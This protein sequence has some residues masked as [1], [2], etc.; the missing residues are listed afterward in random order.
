MPATRAV[1]VGSLLAI[2][3]PVPLVLL[4]MLALGARGQEKEADEAD[5]VGEAAAE[6]DPDDLH[7]LNVFL[8]PPRRTLRRLSQARE[9]IARERY[10]DAVRLL[11][12]VLEGDTDYFFQPD[13][14]RPLHRSLKVAAQQL[15]GGIPAEGRELYELQ[16]GPRAQAL[17]EAVLAGESDSSLTEISRRYFH[18]RAGYE[19]TFLLGLREFDQGRPLAAALTLGRLN[20]ALRD[21]R[22][23]PALSLTLAA[24]WL[25]ADEPE[26]ARQALV[27][28][29]A[30]QGGRAPRFAGKPVRWFDTPETA[31]SWLS[32]HMGERPDAAPRATQLWAMVGG[33]PDRNASVDGGMPLLS[34]R[35]RIPVANDRAIEELWRHYVQRAVHQKT[36]V[37]PSLAPLVVDDVVLMRTMSSLLAVDARTG[38]RLWEARGNEQRELSTDALTRAS[39]Q[40]RSTAQRL[41]MQLL[42]RISSDA[43][44]GSLSSDGRLVFAVEDTQPAFSQPRQVIRNA[45]TVSQ[46]PDDS[47]RLAAY[48]VRSGK[49][50]WHLGGPPEDEFPLRQAGSYF[51]GPPLPLR[52]R[53]YVLAEVRGEVSLRVL[54]ANKGDLLWSQPLAMVEP[55]TYSFAPRRYRGLSPSYRDGILICPTGAG[56][57]VAVDLASRSLLW[58]YR[59]EQDTDAHTRQRLII[60]QMRGQT[61]GAA[62]SWA[63]FPPIIADGR[64][65]VAASNAPD[66]IQCLDLLSGDVVWE[67][68]REDSIMVGCVWEGTILLIGPE[69][70]SA[71]KL[72]DGRLAWEQRVV[73]LPTDARPSG[74]GFLSDGL[75]FLPLSTGEIAAI[76]VERGKLE[77]ITSSRDELVPGHLVCYGNLVI[78]QALDGL[79]AFEQRA[80]L[81]R[82]VAAALAKNPNDPRALTRRAELR[83]AEGDLLDAVADLRRAMDQRPDSRTR[84]LLAGA[85][86]EGL[87]SNF[88]QFHPMADQL[89]PLLDTLEQ[90]AEYH[91]AMA[92]GLQES[93]R[94]QAALSHYKQ[95]IL[96]G[97]DSPVLEDVSPFHAVARDRL[98]AVG[99]HDLYRRARP[100]A[101]REIDRYIADQVAEATALEGTG[102]LRELISYFGYSPAIRPARRELLE[103]LVA[104]NRILEAELLLWDDY[105]SDN[106]DRAGP[107][108]ARLAKMM[109]EIGRSDQA[110]LVYRELATRFANV[111][112][113]GEATGAEIVAALPQSH[114]AHSAH[115]ARGGVTAAAFPSGSVAMEQRDLKNQ[116]YMM[117]FV[118]RLEGDGGPFLQHHLARL[119]HSRRRFELIDGLGREVLSV[120]FSRN[121]RVH[122]SYGSDEIFGRLCG[123]LLVARTTAGA[124]A[125]N[126]LRPE[127]EGRML[128]WPDGES[129]DALEDELALG[130]VP[131]QWPGQI[132]FARA[133]VFSN[134]RHQ[135]ELGPVSPDCAVVAQGGAVTGHD[136][137]SGRALW[138]RRDLPQVDMI[139]GDHEYTVVAQSGETR[140]TILRMSDGSTLKQVPM[141][142]GSRNMPLSRHLQTTR[143]R[144]FLDSV[145]VDNHRVIGLYDPVGEKYVWGPKTFESSARVDILHGRAVGV[146]ENEGRFHLLALA[147]GRTLLDEKLP[148]ADD[149]NQ[150]HL[151][152][153]GDDRGLLLVNKSADQRVRMAPLPGTQSQ[154]IG[155]GWIYAFQ[156]QAPGAAPGATN[157][158]SDAGAT[159][160]DAAEA[161]G[162]LLWDKPT[163][164]E[165]QMLIANQPELLPVLSFASRIIRL[166]K[167]NRVRG[168]MPT[169]VLC[170][171]KRS[172]RVVVDHEVPNSSSAFSVE[173]KPSDSTVTIALQ[174][175]ELLLRFQDAEPNRDPTGEQAKPKQDSKRDPEETKNGPAKKG[176]AK[177]G[178]EEEPR[179]GDNH[180]DEASDD[181]AEAV[182]KA[183]GKALVP[184][185]GGA[186]RIQIGPRIVIPPPRAER[187][188]IIPEKAPAAKGERDASEPAAEEPPAK[189]E[190]KTDAKN[191]REERKEQAQDAK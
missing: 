110:A 132:G 30:S 189:Q 12:E 139:F 112:C 150:I 130:V 119:N 32:E 147:D 2:V 187:V 94:W 107:A 15:L 26:K 143:G 59:Y 84:R 29:K 67:A 58:G 158:A 9:L 91:R 125:L 16:Q 128:L 109:D 6:A 97:E 167:N 41:A 117:S 81:Q 44:Y 182:I 45:R 142:E 73:E 93:G 88:P 22:F 64:V 90:Q 13:R 34:M 95:L 3:L 70:V 72:A 82:Q 87:T 124:V 164:V 102:H 17:L 185:V 65:L 129:E 77:A 85:L 20:R 159:A 51:L 104:A 101:R 116:A 126:T 24:C 31:V 155:Q 80:P 177:K 38:K 55:E 138:T 123:H 61:S 5:A 63:E 131:G 106:P 136:P 141:P 37:I 166:D 122:I 146:L 149:A 154:L 47:N 190:K 186:I 79:V 165:N 156:C 120:D 52:G 10:G 50:K 98:V 25:Q 151:I 115:S 4:A 86:L 121:A 27:E 145:L 171:D 176:P 160:G 153:A 66:D 152:P 1:Q 134:Q 60:A 169:Q 40:S 168:P 8:P 19:A 127:D 69:K 92:A 148:E 181:S 89:E 173:G 35:W 108:A 179:Q 42:H 183:I 53:L 48:G 137:I 113:G 54:D 103:R 144:C 11:G 172:G 118:S 76:D 75:Y 180:N 28:L 157:Q 36:P 163:K 184:G 43:T 62:A 68:P 39:R 49:L 56:A 162:R 96:L 161:H 23:E 114:P 74:R 78:S 83:L 133:V 14:D 140:L 174:R 33:N 170:V 188:K 7:A 175:H 57:I 99:L 135:L 71:R 21:D 178:A 46:S 191:G 105:R 100:E 18:T 111:V